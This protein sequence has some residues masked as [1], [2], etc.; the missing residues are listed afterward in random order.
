MK[1]GDLVRVRL[2][3]FVVEHEGYGEYN[4]KLG[5]IIE[6]KKEGEFGRSLSI[7]KVMLTS[8]EMKS[9]FEHTLE[10]IHETR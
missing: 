8:G 4:D 1:P 2:P 3:K 5:V 9:F 10:F 7:W 6:L